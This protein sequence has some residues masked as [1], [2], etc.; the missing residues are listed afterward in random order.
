MLFS[1]CLSRPSVQKIAQPLAS[2]LLI[3]GTTP[4]SSSHLTAVSLS[5]IVSDGITTVPCLSR[6]PSLAGLR[7]DPRVSLN[8]V[9]NW[10]CKGPEHVIETCSNA[11]AS[12]QQN[13]ETV[14]VF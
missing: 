9:W 1:A 7:T 12:K 8:R 3:A 5:Q 10:V 11:V 6:K 4:P 2:Q 14:E 13:L